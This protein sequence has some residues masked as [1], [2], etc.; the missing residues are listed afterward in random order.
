[1][2]S[3]ENLSN[4]MEM[5]ENAGFT[6]TPTNCWPAERLRLVRPVHRRSAG[7]LAEDDS[8]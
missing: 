2:A 6:L 8:F 1:M 5:D 4:H 3:A 7:A